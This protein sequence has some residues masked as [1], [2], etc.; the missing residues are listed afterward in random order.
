MRR[1]GHEVHPTARLGPCL[2]IGVSRITLAEGSRVGPFN[3]FRDL[4][5]FHL[6][7]AAVV[8]QWNWISAAAPLVS[9]PQHGVFSLGQDSALT[10]RHYVDASG[11]VLIGQFTTVAGVRS[12]FI[13]HGIDWKRS[14]QT[15][16]GITVGD[17]CLVS[18]NVCLAPG[19]TI[20]DRSVIGMGETVAGALDEAGALYLSG[21]AVPVKS[22]LLGKYFSR[23]RGF[24]NPP[25][26][27]DRLIS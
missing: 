21:R 23:N 24:V 10:S 19:T 5:G 9:Q 11:G 12:T 1:L 4:Q 17:Y 22:D 18:S 7:R 15:V 6:D 27:G 14:E 13:T 3:V 26:R 16:K 8:G 2:I 20:A 25:T